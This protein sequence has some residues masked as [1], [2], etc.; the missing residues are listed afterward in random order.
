MAV[1][2]SFIPE[3]APGDIVKMQSD[4]MIRDACN[5]ARREPWRVPKSDQYN[6]VT[7]RRVHGQLQRT[8]GP[9]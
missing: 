1:I 6:V 2:G 8:I 9:T 7:G 3:K 4:S 5:L